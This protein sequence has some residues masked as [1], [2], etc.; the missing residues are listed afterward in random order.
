MPGFDLLIGNDGDFVDDGKGGLELTLTAQ[1]SIR[2]QILDKLGEWI[3]DCEAGRD[4]L[5]P[6]GRFSTEA[7]LTDEADRVRAALKPLESAGIISDI[8]IEVDRDAQGRF[9]LLI[10]CQDTQSGGIVILSNTGIFGG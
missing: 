10:R 4:I 9:G 8:D 3:G 6:G 1:P 7:E 2:H 5:D